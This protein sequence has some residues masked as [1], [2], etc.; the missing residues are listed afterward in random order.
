MNGLALAATRA[1]VRLDRLRVVHDLHY[2]SFGFHQSRYA[3][4]EPYYVGED[5]WFVLGDNSEDSS[6]SR[7]TGAVARKDLRGRP[8]MIVSPL[9]RF[10]MLTR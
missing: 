3:V 5:R 10:R 8:W 1:P 6:D 2:T 9:R 7:M 4:E